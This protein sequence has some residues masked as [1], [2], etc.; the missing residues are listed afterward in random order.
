M[1]LEFEWD[2]CPQKK[3]KERQ[4]ERKHGVSFHEAQSCFSD[5]LSLSI[6]D[7]DHSET[8]RR[9]L[10]LGLSRL[11]RLLVKSHTERAGKIR[12]ISAR[13][14]SRGETRAYESGS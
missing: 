13:R 12:I 6:P 3:E 4:N 10:L 7:V 14:A 5:H 11:G 1:I 2:T 8:E 9:Y